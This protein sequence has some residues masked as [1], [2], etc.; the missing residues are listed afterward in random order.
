MPA[1]TTVTLELELRT[2]ADVEVPL[3][4]PEAERLEWATQVVLAL[5]DG[6]HRSDVAVSH[7]SEII[8]LY[9][10]DARAARTP[11]PAGM[12]F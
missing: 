11:P 12:P 3:T 10:A 8:N 7:S 6:D 2:E 9:P 4:V 1:T 5:W